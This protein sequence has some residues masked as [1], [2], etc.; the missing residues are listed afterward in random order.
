M[1]KKMTFFSM[2]LVYV[3]SAQNQKLTS[4]RNAYRPADRIVKQQ[5]EYKD[6]GSTGKELTWDFRTLQP[7]NEEYKLDYFIPDSTHMDTLCGMEHSTRYY[8]SQ[9]RDSLWAVG[10]ENYTTLMEYLKPELKLRFPFG[11][12]DTL[13]SNFEGTGQYSHRLDLKLKATPVWKP[14]PKANYSFPT[15]RQ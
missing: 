11:Y 4:D 1:R 3:L 9:K 13:R 8:Y 6:P 15:S 7:I 2:L 10:F 12:G 14:M 5:V